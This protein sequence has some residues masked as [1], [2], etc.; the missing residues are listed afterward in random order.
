MYFSGKV[1]IEAEDLR[2]ERAAEPGKARAEREG[3]GE[4]RVD[5]DAEPARDALIVDRGAQPA[6]EA[7]FRQR[8]LQRDREQAADD[9]DQQ[10]V[11]ADA[12][13]EHVDLALQH[14]RDLH[15]LLRGAHDVVDGRD[16]HE[17]EADGE[18]HLV[19]MALG[20]DVDVE[21]A[22]E[23]RAERGG[24]QERE[25]QRRENGTPI[26]LTRTTVT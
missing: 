6:A 26:R 5:I 25:R 23:Q 20:V 24:H 8:K 9:D 2:A 11:V 10:P 17:H 12:D 3:H 21:R 22:L 7:R 4:H 16:R 14:L 18:Q 13:A 15:E 1:G 19:E